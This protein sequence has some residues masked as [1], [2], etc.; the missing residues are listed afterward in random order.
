MGTP[1]LTLSGRSYISRMAGSL[2]TAV[3]LPDLVTFSLPE[4][5]QRAI[6]IGQQPARATSYKRYLAEFGRSSP[7]FDMP[8]LV[9]DMESQFEQMA[10]LKRAQALA[11]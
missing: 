9:R 11:A 8:A 5:E 10:G 1:I 4:Y 6:Q 2:L 7:L 3:G